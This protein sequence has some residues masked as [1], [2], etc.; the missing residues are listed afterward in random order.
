MAM[1]TRGRA[2]VTPIEVLIGQVET[3]YPCNRGSDNTRT[4]IQL[5]SGCTVR[6]NEDFQTVVFATRPDK[7]NE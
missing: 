6:V 1:F 5:K 4:V 7:G 2:C 3:V